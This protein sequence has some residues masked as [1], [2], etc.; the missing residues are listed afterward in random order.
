MTKAVA[1]GGLGFDLKW[2]LGWM[3]DTLAYFRRDA[4]LR[5]KHQKLLTFSLTYAFDEHFVLP[6]SHDEVVHG[7][8][9]LV[10]KMP[11][12]R[13]Q[14]FA[15]LRALLG[16]QFG[17]PGKK[18]LFMGSELAPWNE[19]NH[20]AQLEWDL[21]QHEPHQQVRDWLK[22]LL[23]YYRDSPALHEIDGSWS[24]FEWIDHSDEERSVVAFVRRARRKD[25]HVVIVANF[26]PMEWERYRL[27]VP[28]A[29]GYAVV[30][31]SDDERFGG[32]A[33]RAGTTLA[34]D[35]VPAHEREQSVEIT[36]PPLSI[37]FLEPAAGGFWSKDPD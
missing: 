26:T 16:F 6:L 10:A 7:K 33:V 13:P 36:L 9:S 23:R 37:A 8:A 22:A 27:G 2:N 21:L 19:W 20:D 28:P 25:R 24:G 1:E 30:L 29:E 15:N 32:T 12:P 5:R 11:G 14:S 31:D 34:V 35:P 18:L 3:N 4:L 17:H